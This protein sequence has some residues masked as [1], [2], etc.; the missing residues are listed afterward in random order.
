MKPQEP[1][2]Q[3]SRL[4]RWLRCSV[5]GFAAA[6]LAVACGGSADSDRS[7]DSNPRA[8]ARRLLD[9]DA[10]V[11]LRAAL[12]LV[13]LREKA[14]P[15]LPELI[16]LLEH[17]ERNRDISDQAVYAISYIGPSAA[18]AVPVLVRYLGTSPTTFGR[19]AAAQA[20]GAIR[21]HPDLTVPALIRSLD[22]ERAQRPV[23]CRALGAFGDK[24]APAVPAVIRLLETV[25]PA[26]VEDLANL[27]NV[28][29]RVG[30][31]AKASVPLLERMLLDESVHIEVRIDSADALGAMGKDASAALTSLREAWRMEAARSSAKFERSIRT[32]IAK[33]GDPQDGDR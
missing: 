5:A 12:R 18:D 14:A 19:T 4:M 26:E 2:S 20:L 3:P 27:V 30:P 24:A 6:I 32:A 29:R 31:S 28:L 1:S 10:N 22:D 33:I 16:L 15:A 9:P 7:T 11:R 17:P 13:G 8:L 21:S 25:P 23:V